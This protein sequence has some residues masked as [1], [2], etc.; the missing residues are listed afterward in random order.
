[1]NKFP[2]ICIDDFYP[3]PTAIRKFALE[4]EFYNGTG[5]W[6]GKRTEFLHKLNP[7]LFDQFC[8]KLFSVFYD[9]GKSNITW[10]VETAFHLIDPLA[11]S[12]DSPKNKGWIH[13][14]GDISMYAGIVYLTPGADI[15]AG[16]S[17]YRLINK[18]TVDHTDV[19]ESYYLQGIDKQYDETITRHNSS[20]EETVRFNNV[21]NRLVA[22]DSGIYHGINNYHTGNLPRLTQVF[23]IT[24]VNSTSN[25][26]LQ[27]Y[28]IPV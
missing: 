20:F 25:F 23:F 15:D 10:N 2:A 21:Y 4:Q 8:K 19:K 12:K 14:D 6:P 27:R 13:L 18:D 3:D 26:P 5:N 9:F 16:T 24:E 17:M 7:E 1:M 28:Q 22:Y 11:P